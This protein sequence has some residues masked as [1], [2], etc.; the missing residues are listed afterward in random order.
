MCSAMRMLLFVFP[1]AV[2]RVFMLA[3]FALFAHLLVENTRLR[4]FPGGS[5]KVVPCKLD[6]RVCPARST[7][8]DK[9][10]LV[11]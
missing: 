1:G 2:V 11:E 7:N 3:T 9:R 5:Y 6:P 4:A 8:R 10:D